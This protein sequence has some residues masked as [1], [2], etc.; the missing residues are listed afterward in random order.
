[1]S[2]Q[3]WKAGTTGWSSGTT[4]WSSGWG[5][6]TT[7]TGGSSSSSGGTYQAR[8][9][10]GGATG[11]GIR[12]D[13]VSLEKI[14]RFAESPRIQAI[15]ARRKALEESTDDSELIWGQPSEYGNDTQTPEEDRRGFR[16]VNPAPKKDPED[17]RQPTRVYNEVERTTDTVRVYN[18]TNN[19][20]YVDVQR[21]KT[22][23][24]RGPD[25]VDSRF[26]LKPPPGTP[27]P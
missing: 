25:G 8:G 7:T 5:N 19:A 26:V 20:Q 4:G 12:A 21:I 3:D 10:P 22:I 16:I 14:V 23:T 18:P 15:R 27:V 11:A 13:R 24:F 1:M 6:T 9:R 2:T 17:T